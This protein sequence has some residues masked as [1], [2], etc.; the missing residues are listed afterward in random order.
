MIHI[1]Q[2]VATSSEGNNASVKPCSPLTMGSGFCE[3]GR[4][5]ALFRC[6]VLEPYAS[7]PSELVRPVD[8]LHRQHQQRCDT[9]R[10]IEKP[11]NAMAGHICE[12]HLDDHPPT[13]ASSSSRMRWRAAKPPGP[14]KSKRPSRPAR[15]RP[16]A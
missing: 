8:G 16:S 1:N 2:G 15:G 9:C 10:C 3:A 5:S 13:A 12:Y 7:D 4:D 14:L 11:R 6:E